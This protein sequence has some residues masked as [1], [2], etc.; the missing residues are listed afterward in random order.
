MYFLLNT[1]NA[2]I[3]GF[4]DYDGSVLNLAHAPSNN[5]FGFQLGNGANNYN[6]ADNAFGGW[7][8]YSGTFLVDGQQIM[9]GNA[10]GAGDFAFELDCCPDYYITRCWTAIDCSGNVTQHCQTISYEPVVDNAPDQL[11]ADQAAPDAVQS[12]VSVY[13]N[14]A[15]V[16]ATFAVTIAESAKTTIEVYDLA[17]ARVGRMELNQVIAGN[18]YKVSMDVSNL[19]AGIYMYRVTNGSVTEMGRM[20][21]AK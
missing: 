20:I 17:G 12:A 21:V 7:F 2:T 5:Y 8:T 1:G 3:T 4:G 14:P 11:V 15:V 18:E 13:P 6:G 16:A 19:A 9:S 10:A